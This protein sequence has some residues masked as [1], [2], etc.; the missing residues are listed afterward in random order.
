[1]YTNQLIKKG[2]Y[3]SVL[4][5]LIFIVTLSMLGAC[6][7]HTVSN[8]PNAPKNVTPVMPIAETLPDYRVQVGDVLE[9]KTLLS[10]EL[11]EEVIVRPDGKISTVVAQNIMAFGRTPEEIQ[12]ELSGEYDRY[13]N[14]PDVAVIVRTFAPNRVFV[15]GE[16]RDPG[17]QISVGPNLTLVQAI[18]RA[19]GMKN[20]AE[21]NEIVILRRGSS[22]KPEAMVA[23]FEAAVTG[24]E[25][26]ADVR[27]APFDV[28]FVPRLGAAEAFVQY[29]QRF[30]QFFDF[31]AGVNAAY[32][33][34]GGR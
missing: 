12:T 4:K 16:V 20:S 7:V 14:D 2:I 11:N 18:S 5:K 24:L 21:R 29:E 23:N 27:L 25:A 1:M 28:V 13:L 3:M 34:N 22:E 19:G 32:Q 9:I 6:S 15:L 30:K 17:E 8:L 10:P 33:I 31:S 26:N